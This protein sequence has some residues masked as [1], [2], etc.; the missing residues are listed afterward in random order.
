M[1]FVH[2][3][4]EYIQSHSTT[5]RALSAEYGELMKWEGKTQTV[6]CK[7]AELPS[8]Y[9]C[10]LYVFWWTLAIL[11]E[12]LQKRILFTFFLSIWNAIDNIFNLTRKMKLLFVHVCHELQSKFVKALFSNSISFVWSL[13]VVVI[14]IWNCLNCYNIHIN[15]HMFK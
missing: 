1:V 6:H 3:L 15:T 13:C 8:N 2:V 12:F 9:V 11:Y 14:A 5:V 4:Y 10:T 7:C